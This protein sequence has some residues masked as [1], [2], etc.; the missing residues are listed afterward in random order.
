MPAKPA[1][2]CPEVSGRTVG[3]PA[4]WRHLRQTE[5]HAFEGEMFDLMDRVCFRQE[6]LTEDDTDPGA[7]LGRT[8]QRVRSEFVPL[9]FLYDLRTHGALAHKPD[10]DGQQRQQRSSASQQGTGA[11][12]TTCV[13]S[14]SLL[15][16]S[17]R[18]VDTC[19]LPDR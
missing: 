16:A 14:T 8:Y 9:A 15:I 10:K 18:S 6:V 11:A 13:F 3:A 19:T 2:A 17:E 7:E 5:G 1:V 12:L 4:R